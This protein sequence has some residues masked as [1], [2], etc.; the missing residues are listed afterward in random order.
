MIKEWLIQAPKVIRTGLCDE[1]SL[2]MVPRLGYEK[3]QLTST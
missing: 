2:S 1:T 3:D